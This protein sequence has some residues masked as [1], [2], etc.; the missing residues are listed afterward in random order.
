VR[1]EK[2]DVVGVVR[3]RDAGD[4]AVGRFRSCAWNGGGAAGWCVSAPGRVVVAV[5]MVGVSS[6]LLG[7]LLCDVVLL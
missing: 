6:C 7:V 2:R 5:G 4:A 3:Y 1:D